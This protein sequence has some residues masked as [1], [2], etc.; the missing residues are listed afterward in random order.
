MTEHTDKKTLDELVLHIDSFGK[1]LTEWEKGFIE[2]LIEK[3]PAAYS[4]KQAVQIDRI[5]D[6]RC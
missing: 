6:E 3:P 2:R 4:P 1:K 5:Y